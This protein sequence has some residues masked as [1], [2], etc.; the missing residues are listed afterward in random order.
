MAVSKT[1]IANMALDH[2]GKELIEDLATENSSNARICRRHYDRVRRGLL[3]RHHWRFAKHRELLIERDEDVS[4]EWTY[5]FTYPANVL[6]IRYIEPSTGLIDWTNMPEFE[7]VGGPSTSGDTDIVRILTD[8][9]PP[10]YAV[11]TRN[12]E[13]TALFPELFVQAFALALAV[14]VYG[15]KV[16][17]KAGKDQLMKDATLAYDAATAADSQNALRRRRWTPGPIAAR[18]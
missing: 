8:E 2:A 5:S 3:E 13:N 12:V 1:E 6:M 15:S 4:P 17:D 11:F 14:V 7:L 18:A 16:R 10:A 9:A